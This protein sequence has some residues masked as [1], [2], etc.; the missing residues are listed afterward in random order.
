[1]K[2]DALIRSYASAISVDIWQDCFIDVITHIVLIPLYRRQIEST[3]SLNILCRLSREFTQWVY[4]SHVPRFNNILSRVLSPA[5]MFKWCFISH[6]LNSYYYGGYTIWATWWYLCVRFKFP[7]EDYIVRSLE[8]LP[9]I[10]NVSCDQKALI[11][12]ISH[13]A[14]HLDVAGIAVNVEEILRVNVTKF[15]LI[16]LT[17]SHQIWMRILC[18]V[19]DAWLITMVFVYSGVALDECSEF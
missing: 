13:Q 2:L 3:Q 12:P 9:P 1:M 16:L 19:K 15:N 11:L 4:Y 18:L 14:L 17:M 7:L 5:H 10:R 6:V 8:L